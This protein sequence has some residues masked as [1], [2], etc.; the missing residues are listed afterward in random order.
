VNTGGSAPEPVSQPFAAV[1]LMANSRPLNR[2]AGGFHP[3]AATP[4][5]AVPSTNFDAASC[6]DSVLGTLQ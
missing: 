2:L 4:S 6:H 3:G 1:F 5:E